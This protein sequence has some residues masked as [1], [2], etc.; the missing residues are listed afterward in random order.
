MFGLRFISTSFQGGGRR[1]TPA[2]KSPTKVRSGRALAATLGTLPGALA[3]PLLG[4]ALALALVAPAP[5]HA[6]PFRSR[7]GGMPFRAR[8]M[9]SRPPAMRMHPMM[10]FHARPM[11]HTP[12]VMHPSSMMHLSARPTPSQQMRS[13]GTTAT[14]TQARQLRPAMSSTTQMRSTR[15]TAT[16]T[17]ARQLRPALRS[18]TPTARALVR[19]RLSRGLLNTTR[20]SPDGLFRLSS[21]SRRTWGFPAWLSGF[22]PGAGLYYGAGGYGAGSYGGGSGGGSSGGGSGGGYSGGG[23]GGAGGYGGG[24]D[25]ASGDYGGGGYGL[26][27]NSGYYGAGGYGGYSGAA[28]PAQAA[29]AHARVEVVLPANADVWFNGQK[30]PGTDTRRAYVSPTLEASET[31]PYRV[32]VV[33]GEGNRVERQGELGG[34]TTAVIDFTQPQPPT[35]VWATGRGR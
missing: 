14:S 8:P 30:D 34:G 13:T 28:A 1:L 5:A 25:S 6:Q 26:A 3:L 4:C 16:S 11:M 31:F 19:S 24:S 32:V 7:A 21:L 9:M 20:F 22:G 27:A 35:V 17:Q 15:A 12:S 18:T 2:R 23:Y 33:W 10:P 29:L